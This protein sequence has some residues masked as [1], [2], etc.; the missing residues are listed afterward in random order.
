MGLPP[1]KSFSPDLAPARFLCKLTPFK[2]LSKSFELFVFPSSVLIG[3]SRSS[4][5]VDRYLSF[6]ANEFLEY[7]NF[8]S[9]VSRNF[10]FLSLPYVP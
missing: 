10:P 2:T 7:P 5:N 4:P 9:L 6:P 3:D 8:T 1:L